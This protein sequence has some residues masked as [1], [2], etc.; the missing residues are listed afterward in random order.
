MRQFFLILSLVIS[1]IIFSPSSL[2]F[3]QNEEPAAE[4]SINQEELNNLIET[5]ETDEKR[6][7]FIANLKTLSDVAETNEEE[8]AFSLAEL[9]GLDAPFQAIKNQY[10]GLLDQYN[11][12]SSSLSNIIATAIIILAALLLMYINYRLSIKIKNKMI[13]FKDRF[14]LS[15]DRLH[16]YTRILRFCGHFLDMSLFFKFLPK[17]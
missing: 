13:S 4:V 14:D 5:L 17:T 11:I 9:I 2:A 6:E 1:A 3:A 7:E 12:S 8:K 15:H 16:T 10:Q